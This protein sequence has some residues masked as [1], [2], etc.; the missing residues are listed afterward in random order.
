MG[1]RVDSAFDKDTAFRTLEIVNSWI[2]AADNKSSILLAFVGLLVGLSTRM[3][4]GL[5]A[6]LES[7]TVMEVILGI[8]FGILYIII[9][10]MTVMNLALVFVARTKEKD[11]YSKNIV[12]YVAISDMSGKEYIDNMKNTKENTLIEMISSQISINSKIAIKKM[13]YFNHAL[14]CA[15]FLIPITIVIIFIIS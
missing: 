9:L 12:S 13:R 4:M 7:G 1:D 2:T 15:I 6:F 8:V 10:V 11:L 14:K 5:T 3:Y